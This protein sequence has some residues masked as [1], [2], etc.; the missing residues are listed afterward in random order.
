M[1]YVLRLSRNQVYA[2]YS[3]HDYS[4]WSIH[5]AIVNATLIAALWF[6]A[7]PCQLYMLT[8]MACAKTFP[9]YINL[10]LTVHIEKSLFISYLT[11][12]FHIDV[13]I[14]I[15]VSIGCS[16]VSLRGRR[17]LMFLKPISRAATSLKI[18]DHLPLLSCRNFNKRS[19][20][21]SIEMVQTNRGFIGYCEYHTLCIKV[22]KVTLKWL[23]KT[24]NR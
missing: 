21:M 6:S 23:F 22:K 19:G 10:E 7:K 16:L 5:S 17:S 15:R 12:M 18:E 4:R 1:E 20:M 9:Q 2:D 3:I 13:F 8:F 11:H 24:P 14:I